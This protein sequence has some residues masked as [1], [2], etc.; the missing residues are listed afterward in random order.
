[1]LNWE[2]RPTYILSAA[3]TLDGAPGRILEME[4]KDYPQI[5]AAA[6]IDIGNGIPNIALEELIAAA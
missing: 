2:N 3:V 1:M 6:L 4:S 5:I